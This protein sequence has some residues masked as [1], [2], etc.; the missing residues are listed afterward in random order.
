MND[1]KD[2]DKKLKARVIYYNC[3][4]PF[5]AEVLDKAVADGVKEFITIEDGVLNGG[6]GECVSQRLCGKGVR[7]MSFG[8]EDEFVPH[9]TVK[10]LKNSLGLEPSQIYRRY[11]Q[12][13]RYD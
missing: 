3:L 11:L 9:G 2:D 7:V 6:F 10:E 13:E 4:K 8:Y 1:A 12:G 5:D